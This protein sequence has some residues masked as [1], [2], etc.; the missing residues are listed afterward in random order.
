MEGIPPVSDCCCVRLSAEPMRTVRYAANGRV[1]CLHMRRGFDEYRRCIYVFCIP[2][3]RIFLSGGF[4]GLKVL[5]S[6]LVIIHEL[7]LVEVTIPF[8]KSSIVSTA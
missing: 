3:T 5:V 1:W 4:D 2:F 8:S 7:R 6:E